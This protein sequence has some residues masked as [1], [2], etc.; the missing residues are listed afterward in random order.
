MQAGMLVRSFQGSEGKIIVPGLGAVVAT[1]SS[2]TLRRED[3]GRAG[4]RWSLH[5]VL[6]YQNDVLLGNDQVKKKIVCI[7]SKTMKFE[8]CDYERLLLGG[9]SLKVEGVIQCQ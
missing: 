6:S 5:A 7:L 8:L 2:W 1:F 9:T 4:P 3:T